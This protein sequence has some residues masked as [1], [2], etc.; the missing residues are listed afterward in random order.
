MDINVIQLVCLLCTLS[1]PCYEWL[2]SRRDQQHDGYDDLV[3]VNEYG[4]LADGKG[5]PL[6]F[7]DDVVDTPQT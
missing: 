4:A 3:T 5:T 7:V 1:F 6:L 2:H